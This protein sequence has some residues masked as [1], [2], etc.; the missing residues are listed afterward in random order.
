MPTITGGRII[1]GARQDWRGNTGVGTGPF[2]SPG[3]PA[4]G[5]LNNVAQPG[6]TCIDQAAGTLY[7]NTGTL[8]ATVW[9][10]QGPGI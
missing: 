9:P 7:A 3:V 5:Y 2:A 6:A 10:L 4:N 8:A 1:E